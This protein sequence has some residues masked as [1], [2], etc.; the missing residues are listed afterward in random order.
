MRHTVEMVLGNVDQTVTGS[1][2]TY[3]ELRSLD[4]ALQDM[5]GELT[6]NLSKLTTIDENI[7]TEERKLNSLAPDDVENKRIIKDRI[8]TL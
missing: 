4:K 6:N 2:F 3:R 1:E 5:R 8:K 7:A